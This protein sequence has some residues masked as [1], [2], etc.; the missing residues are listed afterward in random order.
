MNPSKFPLG[1]VS[2]GVLGVAVLLFGLA[3]TAEAACSANSLQVINFKGPA[4]GSITVPRDL[5][6]GEVIYQERIP[7]RNVQFNCQSQD[8]WGFSLA[9]GRGAPPAGVVSRFP[10]GTPGLLFRVVAPLATGDLHIPSLTN[11]RA[12]YY[13]MEGGLT[14]K[15]VKSGQLAPG[16]VVAPGALGTVQAGSAVFLDLSLG[17]AINVVAVSCETPDVYVE[18]G[19]DYTMDDFDAPGSTTRAVPFNIRLNDCP[20]G[21]NKVEYKLQAVTPVIDAA[22]GVVGLNSASD[23]VGI[24]LQIKDANGMPVPL[25]TT[26][27]FSGYR[28]E[29]GNFVIPL[30]ASYYRLATKSI[31]P[32]TANSEVAFIMSYL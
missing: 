29:G 25:D 24:G 28:A 23:A 5:P 15:I 20:G 27:T 14:L 9:P 13:Q 16:N 26:R 17:G 10:T 22:R 18:M 31:R 12:G 19:D 6:E 3:S 2:F 11:L 7:F 30:T 32:G 4:G 8:L 21:I 1:K